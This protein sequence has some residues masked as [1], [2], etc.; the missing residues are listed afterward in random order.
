VLPTKNETDAKQRNNNFPHKNTHNRSSA[1]YYWAAVFFVTNKNKTEN[2]RSAFLFCYHD[3]K[4]Y[5]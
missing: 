2:G 3:T 4:K 5:V 1:K